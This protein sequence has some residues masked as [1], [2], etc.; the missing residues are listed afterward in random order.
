MWT[1]ASNQPNNAPFF[2]K[3][4]KAFLAQWRHQIDSDPIG[5]GE[6]PDAHFVYCICYYMLG[7]NLLI[8]EYYWNK[9]ASQETKSSLVELLMLRSRTCI[10]STQ[11]FLVTMAG[12][13]CRR[14]HSP[15]LIIASQHRSHNK[16]LQRDSTW[17]QTTLW[18]K[19][20]HRSSAPV[21]NNPTEGAQGC[22]VRRVR[23]E[24]SKE[25]LTPE[26]WDN[27][28]G[29]DSSFI[30]LQ[31]HLMNPYDSWPM[32]KI[33]EDS[34]M[35]QEQHRI[36]VSQTG[37]HVT[38]QHQKSTQV[39]Q[40]SSKSSPSACPK[41]VSSQR[42]SR[43]QL[44]AGRCSD[45]VW[46]NL[47]DIEAQIC[48]KGN[49]ENIL[50]NSMYIYNYIYIIYIYIYYKY[51]TIITTAESGPKPYKWNR[52]FMFLSWRSA[53]AEGRTDIAL[54]TSWRSNVD[55]QLW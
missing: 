53:K 22:H 44:L 37:Y 34:K 10:P 50:W 5:L 48:D 8:L 47:L 9:R 18:R 55:M 20:T 43:L 11:R 25:S 2:G 23:V 52:R 21:G 41:S 33:H 19:T 7:F 12:F 13:R 49:H 32:P 14:V 46:V 15:G 27:L 16:H 45:N 24:F 40:A 39:C 6:V 26:A 29:H 17:S 31:N 42:V 54:H 28:M 51:G 30:R 38:K 36:L 1:F 35:H 4:W 3:I